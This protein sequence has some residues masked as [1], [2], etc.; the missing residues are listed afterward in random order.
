M[1]PLSPAQSSSCNHDKIFKDNLPSQLPKTQGRSTEYDMR[2][3]KK[4]EISLACVNTSDW[5]MY[6]FGQRAKAKATDSKRMLYGW[7]IQNMNKILMASNEF[8]GNKSK[9]NTYCVS[10]KLN[11]SGR[12]SVIVTRTKERFDVIQTSR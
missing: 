12:K 7:T 5:R 4:D 1:L 10:S 11:Y 9:Y 6:L 2:R 3:Y 8:N